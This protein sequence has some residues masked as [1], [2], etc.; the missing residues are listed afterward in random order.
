MNSN[1]HYGIM[2]PSC[3]D[4]IFSEHRHDYKSCKCGDVTIDGGKD[5]LR[6]GWANHLKKED[7]FLVPRGKE[8]ITGGNGA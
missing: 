8:N 4:I 7:V 5:Y 2:C 6:Y 3:K 1:P